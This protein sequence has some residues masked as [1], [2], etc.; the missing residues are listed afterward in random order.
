MR[1]KRRR[2]IHCKEKEEDD[3]ST[4]G[5]STYPLQFF[6]FLDAN[7]VTDGARNPGRLTMCEQ[8]INVVKNV[9]VQGTQQVQLV[10]NAI[11]VEIIQ[12]NH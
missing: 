2:I 9:V 4:F 10:Q 11:D 8:D 6:T 12:I 5:T 3:K 1:I 7:I